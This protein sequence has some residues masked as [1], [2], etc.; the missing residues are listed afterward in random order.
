MTAVLTD[1]I[2]ERFDADNLDPAKYSIHIHYLIEFQKKIGWLNLFK[3]LWS[4]RWLSI[5]EEYCEN[6]NIPQNRLWTI[7]VTSLCWTMWL[8]L[9][10]KR[11]WYHHGVE[12]YT[13][14]QKRR[15][16]LEYQLKYLYDKKSKTLAMD[17]DIF[18]DSVE[19]HLVESTF[20][21]KMWISINKP[22][23]SLSMKE[24]KKKEKS[25]NVRFF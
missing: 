15:Q 24:K 4:K 16:K 11:N 12:Q 18:R 14:L 25:K 17:Q 21:I 23:I 22:L 9:W 7:G 2:Q 13:K 5:H 1:G 3:G 6:N 20:R 8:K 10:K 19:E